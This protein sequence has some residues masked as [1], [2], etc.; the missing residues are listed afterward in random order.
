MA[1]VYAKA[2][3]DSKIVPIEDANLNITTPAILYGLNFYTVFPVCRTK[4]G[5]SA[6]RIREHFQRLMHSSR[7]LA[8]D[9]FEKAWTEKKF[10]DAVQMVLTANKVSEDV[11]VRVTVHA[12]DLMPGMRSRGIGTSLSIFLLKASPILSQSSAR[13]KT[14]LWRRISDS[15]IP[16]RAKVN[17]A[18]VN[19]VLGKQEALD[20]GYDDCIFLDTE[21]HVCE[22]SAANIF[23]VR[24]G[25]LITPGNSSDILEGINRKTV[26]ELAQDMKIPVEERLVDLTELY[27]ADEVFAS[28]TSVFIA[29]VTE[30]DK[31]RIGNGTMGR[32]TTIMQKKHLAVLHGKET[33]YKRYLTPMGKRT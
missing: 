28:G 27:A 26:I 25:T 17:G 1:Q 30:I 7:I 16:A 11:F 31:R 9:T 21:G 2:F 19:S 8:F 3:F 6:F 29:P 18:Y 23:L 10:V 24:D 32:I 13:L 4:N 33:G 14:T 20:N 5:L 15:S 22:L 12:S